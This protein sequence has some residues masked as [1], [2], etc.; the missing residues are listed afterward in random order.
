MYS[1]KELEDILGYTSDQLRLRLD[2]F[3]PILN[4]HIRRGN[5]NKILLNDNGLEKLRRVKDLE[6]QNVALNEISDRLE[7]EVN[8]N[9]RETS[10]N[11]AQTDQNLIEEKDKRIQELKD[12]V[13]ELQ[14]DKVYFQNQVEELQQKLLPA[15]EEKEVPS[16]SPWE[17]LK[18]WLFE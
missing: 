5:N 12:R 13:R 2:R 18:N 9:G 6:K 10:D 16:A 8:P 14:K 11:L 1:I 7:K 4:E 3:R 15:G 17:L